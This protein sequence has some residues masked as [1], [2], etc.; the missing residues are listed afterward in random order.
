MSKTI[1]E[2]L[3]NEFIVKTEDGGTKSVG[4]EY[5]SGKKVLLYFSAHWCPPCRATTPKLAQRYNEFLKGNNCEVIFLSSDSDKDSFDDYFKEMPW[6]AFPFDKDEEKDAISEF[7]DVSGIPTLV[8]L[9]ENY[10]IISKECRDM[11]M[12]DDYKETFPYCPPTIKSLLGDEFIVK[13]EDGGTKSV[14]MEYFSGKKMLLYFSAHWCPPCRATTPKLAERYNEFLKG[15]NC[16]VIFLSSDSDKDS[17]DDYFKEMPWAALPYAKRNEKQLLS[18]KFDVSGIPSL[19]MLDENLEIISKNC[20]GM[21]MADSYKETFPYKP[22]PLNDVTESLDGIN[23]FPSMVFFLESL[24]DSE[25]D[26]LISDIIKPFATRETEAREGEKRDT[27][28]FFFTKDGGPT[29][30]IREICGLSE[31][32]NKGS[33][34]V[35]MRIIDIRGKSSY[36]PSEGSEA[37]TEDNLKKFVEDFSNKRLKKLNLSF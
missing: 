34:S 11:V 32:E 12:A 37:V 35:L 30:Q 2:L 31:D 22:L 36:P 13:T 14:G 5:F 29:P 33:K 16:E 17:F 3:G 26:S 25:R 7:F 8:M 15:N 1:K 24:S 4:M 28:K 19:I 27:I 9:D 23:E 20:R 21:I 10:E 6:I 18:S